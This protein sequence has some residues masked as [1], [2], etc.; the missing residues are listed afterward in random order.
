LKYATCFFCGAAQL[1][2][3]FCYINI[4]H[5]LR[6]RFILLLTLSLIVIVSGKAQ[7]SDN[8]IKF[9]LAQSYERSGDYES[10]VKIYAE[11]YTKDSTN[12]V[13]FDA[14]RRDY[15]QLKRYDDVIAL[16]QRALARNPNDVSVLAQLGTFYTQ[17]NDDVHATEIWER[18]LATAPANEQTYRI[19][20]STMAESRL[21]D[22]AI[23]VYQRAR[24]ACQNPNLFTSEMALLSTI[25][26]NY[27]VATQEYLNMVRQTPSMLSSV[28]SRMASYTNRP[29]GLTTAITM[30]EA[31]AKTEPNNLTLLQLQAWLY[32]EG[33]QYDR[34]YDVYKIIDA[35]TN[36][37][38][39]ELY[40]FAEHALKEKFYSAAAKA[41][42]DVVGLYP[43]FDMRSQACFGLAR[44]LEDSVVALD[45]TNLFSE[46]IGNTPP[47]QAI[48]KMY[49]KIVAAYMNVIK[50]YPS[51]LIAAQSLL[52]IAIL[53][54]ERL[55]DFDA[56]K[57]TLETLNKEYVAHPGVTMEG[58]LRLGDVLLAKGELSKAE[59][60][61][62]LLN[63]YAG[64]GDQKERA[65]FRLAEIDYFKG[66]FKE[67][68][69]KL[70]S[71]TLNVITDIAND[72]M[73]LQVFINDNTSS[74]ETELKKFAEA[75]F[76]KR[77][78]KYQDAI[79][80]F[81]SVISSYPK[82]SLIDEVLMSIGDIRLRMKQYDVGIASYEK[83]I[84]DFP[85]SLAIDIAL[86]KIGRAYDLGLHNIP[87]AIESYQRL[88][89]KYPNS[90]YVNQVRQRIRELRGDTI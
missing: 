19:V 22:K 2:G 68:Q 79:R 46:Y 77:Q 83:L 82:S 59:E 9:R 41:F 16:F 21:F 31:A 24:K 58:T 51:V 73:K 61:Y 67:A 72:A 75:D 37:G 53:Q 43:K 3:F 56:A 48:T 15:L 18:A 11:L 55:L 5:T 84:K 1:S 26:L 23:A 49:D 80:T 76:L 88:L 60:Q 10:A 39:R 44:T 74:G 85:E 63:R 66:N 64:G 47:P 89:E 32:M 38:G 30:T 13:I 81:E 27:T 50:Q 29:E 28:Q 12:V 54:Q 35:K 7:R 17:K 20:A 65:A 90:I 62:M 45:T 69:K 8:D 40:N 87:K 52:R 34:S 14:L 70:R 42:E 6:S 71:L 25:V 33:K 36:A 86:V 4:M 57:S 78:M